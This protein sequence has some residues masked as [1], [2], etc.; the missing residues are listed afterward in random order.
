MGANEIK[1]H[2]RSY[3]TVTILLLSVNLPL[4]VLVA[5]L[6]VTD[7][8]REM[9]RATDARRITL[10]DE[11]S[12]IGNALSR[13]SEPDDVEAST[14]FLESSCAG[15][16]GPDTPGHWI[17][18]R[19]NGKLLHTHT[20]QN[21]HP[22]HGQVGDA[23]V[24]R[25]SAGG[26]QVTI[27]ER[28]AEIRRSVRG[29]AFMHLFVILG[30][31]SLAAIIVNVVLVRLIARPTKLLTESVEKLQSNRFDM[32]PLSFS[33]REL[34][35]FSFKVGQMAKSL[36]Q[37][38]SNRSTAMRRARDI[39]SHL[40]PRRICIPG[41]VFATYFQPAEDVAGDIYG[42][43][44]LRDKSWLIY[45]ADLVGH[46]IPAAISAAV[47]KMVID[48]AAGAATDPGEIMNRVNRALPRYLADGE[49]ATEAILQWNPDTSELSHPSAGHE[50]A[51]LISK[52]KLVTLD[53]TGIPL[54]VDSSACW[55]TRLHA[56]IPGDR[57]LLATDGVAETHSPNDQE[58]GRSRLAE[59]FNNSHSR[60][61]KDFAKHLESEVA[62]HRGTAPIEDDVTYLIAECRRINPSPPLSSETAQA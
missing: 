7:Y 37:A 51:L 16:A 44:Q 32:Q 45:I 12:V 47:L 42:V 29:E 33:S 9:R 36:R 1:D 19:W 34:S 30:L 21:T 58:F 49:F 6:L 4:A 48:S 54:G 5:L 55:A 61:I 24:G 50:P 10:N 20:G 23:L 41:L 57:L 60:D 14:A 46:G 25:F 62:S 8:R 15:T 17:D 11:A 13:F 35:D 18:V 43:M 56:L 26:L 39:Q 38:E 2:R 31:A 27:T 59:M 53:A 3:P 40:L 22:N 28:G 52:Q